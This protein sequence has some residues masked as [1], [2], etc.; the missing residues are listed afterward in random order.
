MTPGSP[1]GSSP[2][3]VCSYPVP[4]PGTGSAQETR[5][6]TI[7]RLSWLE[8]RNAVTDNLSPSD[9]SGVIEPSLAGGRRRLSSQG[10][11]TLYRYVYPVLVLLTFG[12]FVG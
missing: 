3:E 10:M 12:A 6:N 5:D 9:D 8:P 4:Y 7:A 11:T 1:K 2:R